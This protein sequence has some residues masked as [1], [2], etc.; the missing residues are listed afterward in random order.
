MVPYEENK[1]AEGDNGMEQGWGGTRNKLI[2][3]LGLSRGWTGLNGVHATCHF[4]GN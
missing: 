2:Q 1:W 4:F 3:G